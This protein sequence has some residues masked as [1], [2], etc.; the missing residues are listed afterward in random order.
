MHNITY[1]Q[2]LNKACDMAP[3]IDNPTVLFRWAE[4]IIELLAF[5]YQEDYTQVTEDLMIC[6]LKEND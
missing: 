5:I 6:L 1:K 3:T 4:D 2:A